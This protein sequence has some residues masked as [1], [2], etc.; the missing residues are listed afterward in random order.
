MTNDRP[1]AGGAAE[2]GSPEV[3]HPPVGVRDLRVERLDLAAR[4]SGPSSDGVA[5]RAAVVD[6]VRHRLAELWREA[7]DG[8]DV[9]GIALGAVGS[10]GRGD[11]S[12]VSDLDLL[13]VHEGRGHSPEQLAELAQRLWYPIWDAGLDLD[14][15]VRSLAQC[16]QVASKDLPAAV[17]LLDL[18]PVAGDAVVIARARSAL[19]EDWRSAARRR[20][21]ELLASTRQRADQHGE[22]AYRIE[23]ELKEARGGIRDAV[24]LSALAA[25]WLTDRPHG[26]VD[27]AYAHLLDVRD[28]VQVATRRHTNRLL[29]ADQDEVASL[30]GFDDRDDLLASI[31]EAGRVIS[32]ALD[33]TARNARQ[34][35][36][37]PARRP[38]LVRGRR[39]APR[40]RPIAE[41]LVE[42]DGEIVLAVDAR[43][44][45]DPLLSL[46]AAATAA[47]TGLTL[48]PVT[49]ASLT[50]TPPLPTPWPRAAR[51]ALLQ[52]LGSEHAQV[53]IWEALDLAGVV[54]TW[55]PEWAG[56]RNRPQRSP[57]HRHTVDRHLVE[58]V[59]RA[60]RDRK[61]VALGDTLLLA[62]LLHDIG[63]RAGAGDHSVEGARLAGPI[64]TRMG[65]DEQVAADVAR[66]VREHLTL[67]ELATTED[68]E[69]PATVARLLDAVDHRADLLAVLRALTEAD[70]SAAGPA[71][72]SAWRGTL[73]DDLVA[74]AGR[75]LAGT[76]GRP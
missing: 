57:V 63:K 12:P 47:R 72:W 22:L 61:D 24:V 39:A 60:G 59:A 26:A 28:A 46:R 36:Q 34:A 75:V 18:Q 44:A 64:V 73:V 33:T 16:R 27:H 76:L 10:I 48:S 17:G 3:P 68:P 53:P 11:A 42:H 8:Q 15:S 45:D 20:L 67:V 32:Y 70:A 19:L 38:V 4:L 1:P 43:P 37:R 31:A 54:T 40:L 29:L 71:A 66:L 52:L 62:A 35:L 9:N 41:D 69:D 14:H 25:T 55:I 56:V 65:F 30:V 51:S 13:L 74:R 23:P 7:T 6:L 2:H 21:P 5:R 50:A 49:V 58:T